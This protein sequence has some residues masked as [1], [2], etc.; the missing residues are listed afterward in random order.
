MGQAKLRGP[1][2]VRIQQSIARQEQEA[3]EKQERLL[4]QK[5]ERAEDEQKRYD[6]LVEL[7]GEESAAAYMEHKRQKMRDA[8]KMIAAGLT[9]AASSRLTASRQI[10]TIVDLI[11][12]V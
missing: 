2:E 4:Q 5:R 12:R 3:K 11:G 7:Y 8:R 10:Q 6:K 1:L 9:M